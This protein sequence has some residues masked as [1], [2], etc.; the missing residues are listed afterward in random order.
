MAV[1]AL[2]ILSR[3]SWSTVT[4][5]RRPGGQGRII[6]EFLFRLVVV[7]DFEMASDFV[8]LVV[9]HLPLP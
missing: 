8:A 5:R 4:R 6:I 7:F 2:L 1:A 9:I 3:C